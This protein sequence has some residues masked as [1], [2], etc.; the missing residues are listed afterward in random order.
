MTHRTDGDEL[1]RRTEDQSK[2]VQARIVIA[3]LPR[4][5]ASRAAGTR[6]ANAIDL[7]HAE[8]LQLDGS[9]TASLN[10]SF[11]DAAVH[12]LS[13][14]VKAITVTGIQA[15]NARC[16]EYLTDSAAQYHVPLTIKDS[17]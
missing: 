3:E 8:E 12:V 15:V 13:R 6:W 2:S 1:H 10:Q 14:R 9:M 16:R 11:I 4:L 17:E 7:S 5:G